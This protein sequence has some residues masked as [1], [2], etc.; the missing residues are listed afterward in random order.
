MYR[1]ESWAAAAAAERMSF[2]CWRSLRDG[3]EKRKEKSYIV[4]FDSVI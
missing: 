4:E 2:L 1:Y 3:T